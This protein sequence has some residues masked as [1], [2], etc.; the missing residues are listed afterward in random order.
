MSLAL[1]IQDIIWLKKFSKILGEVLGENAVK[2]LFKISVGDDQ[3]ACIA[4]ANTPVLSE[5]TKQVA[6]KYGNLVDN[7]QKGDIGNSLCSN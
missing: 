3:Q 5:Y 1:C 4:D 6:I 7:I 2:V